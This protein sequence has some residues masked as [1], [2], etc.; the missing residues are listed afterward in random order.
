[1]RKKVGFVGCYSHDVILMLTGA[2]G[3]MGKKVLLRD[4]NK[5]HTLSVSVPMPEGVSATK[6]IMEYDGFF[7]TEQEESPEAE[8]DYELE[9]IDFGM[10]IK[11]E[12]AE[13]CSELVVITDMLLHHIRRLNEIGLLK[14]KVKY[15]IMR[16]SFASVCEREQEVSIFLR[17]F[18][19]CTKYFLAPDFRD[20]KNRYVCETLHEYSVSKASPEMQELIYD[21]VGFL[22]PESSGREIRRCIK[23][24]GRRRYR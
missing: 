7:Y 4:R 11:P 10:D 8:E 22:C 17:S 2:L 20:V 21:M 3:C 5:Q 6:T 1:M 23:R 24:Q 9:L 15:C 19:N 12:E 18:P 16:D 14:E 13:R